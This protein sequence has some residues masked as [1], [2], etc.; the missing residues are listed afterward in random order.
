MAQITFTANLQRHV[1]SAS[2]RV[3]GRTVREALE[4]VFAANPRLRSYLLDDQAR[5]RRHVVVYV[6]DAPVADRVG[7]NDPIAADS[8]LFVFQML[9]GG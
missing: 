1:P 9:T 6:D 3:E 5:L 4:G 7:L 2:V 8:R